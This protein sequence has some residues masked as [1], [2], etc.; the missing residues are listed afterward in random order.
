MCWGLSTRRQSVR[1][2][3]RVSASAEVSVTSGKMQA[4][5]NSKTRL[6][7]VSDRRNCT[8]LIPIHIYQMRGPHCNVLD[9]YGR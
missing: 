7:T 4:N 9:M 8:E 3:K 6:A 5:E 1:R 2:D